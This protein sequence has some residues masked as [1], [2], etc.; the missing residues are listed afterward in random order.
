MR[1]VAFI[2]MLVILL[3]LLISCATETEYLTY[4]EYG[5]SFKYPKAFS[6]SVAPLFE[7]QRRADDNSGVV[8][9]RPT[10]SIFPVFAVSWIKVMQSTWETNGSLE[11]SLEDGFELVERHLAG[12]AR[13]ERGEFA[14]TSGAGH[15]MLYQYYTV[16]SIDSEAWKAYGIVGVFYCDNSEK[17]FT[18]QTMNAAVSAKQDVLEDF[19]NYLG[20][21]VC[22]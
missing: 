21:F 14:E 1:N 7:N 12:V 9:V 15:Q 2:S 19:M 22:Y 11:A 5:F 16:T 8:R 20:S 18:L 4:S 10:M 6:V 13:V 17:V 3:A